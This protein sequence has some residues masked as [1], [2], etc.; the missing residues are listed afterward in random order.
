MHITDTLHTKTLTPH[1]P[2]T[3]KEHECKDPN[4]DMFVVARNDTDVLIVRHIP[5]ST[6][7]SGQVKLNS[8]IRE[9]E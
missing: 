9:S 8:L 2:H 6:F 1:T 3:E 5:L 7:P 4:D